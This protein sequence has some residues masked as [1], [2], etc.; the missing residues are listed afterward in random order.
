MKHL[1]NGKNITYASSSVGFSTPS[2]FSASFKKMFGISARGIISL[3]AKIEI[4]NDD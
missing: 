2:H 4:I 3:N 1:S